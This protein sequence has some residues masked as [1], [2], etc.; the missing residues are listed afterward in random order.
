MTSWVVVQKIHSK[1]H[2]VSC[3]NTHRDITDLVNHG[4]VKNTEAWISWEWNIIFLW[5]KKILNLCFRW[6]ILRSYCFVAEV[7]FKDCI[8]IFNFVQT[9]KRKRL[10]QRTWQKITPWLIFKELVQ[11]I[12]ICVWKKI[13][14]FL[15]HDYFFVN[16]FFFIFRLGNIY[17]F[18]WM[19]DGVG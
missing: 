17:F 3:T 15:K 4:M 8:G 14:S 18:S 1:M 9:L 7:T 13:P 19:K 5:N 2:L 10:I 11:K 16:S 12:I 6:H